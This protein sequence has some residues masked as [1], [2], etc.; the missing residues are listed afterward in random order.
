MNESLESPSIPAEA[1]K[2]FDRTSR[3]NR[4]NRVLMENVDVLGL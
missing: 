3:S 1:L 4:F 2:A